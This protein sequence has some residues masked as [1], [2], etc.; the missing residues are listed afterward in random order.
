VSDEH[1]RVELQVPESE[2]RDLTILSRSDRVFAVL[3]GVL[4]LWGLIVTLVAL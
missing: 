4:F 1:P 2:T 3:Y